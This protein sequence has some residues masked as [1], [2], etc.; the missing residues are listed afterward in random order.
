MRILPLVLSLAVFFVPVSVLASDLADLMP[1]TIGAMQ[2]IQLVTGAAAQAEVDA[3]HGKSLPAKASV[4]ARYLRPGASDE[5]PAEVWV[6]RV[7]SKT[8]AR[9]QTGEMVHKMFENPRSP[10]K[11]PR[12]VDH[13][14]RAVYRFEGMGQAHLIWSAGDLV[15]WVSV[16][17]GREGA[18][19]EVLCTSN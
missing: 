6:S 18:M 5:R 4:V 17:P 8:E 3:L 9:R 13:S 11:N 14:G 16:A 2:R 15:Y 10:F 19:L 7:S 1:A 12:R